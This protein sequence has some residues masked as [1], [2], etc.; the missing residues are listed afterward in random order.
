MHIKV[1]I[2]AFNEPYILK[3]LESLAL[4]SLPKSSTIEIIIAINQTQESSDEIKS[5]N[6]NT[7]KICNNFKIIDIKIDTQLFILEKQ[8]VGL[9]RKM[10]MDFAFKK[11]EFENEIKN[12]IIV[13]L[14]ADCE[15]EKNYFLAIEN[16]FIKYP[17]TPATSIFYEHK[18]TDN[19]YIIDYELHL[20]YLVDAL[21]WTGHPYAFQTVGSSMAVRAECYKKQGGMNSKLAGEDFYFLQKMMDLGNFTD[22]LDT[23]VF[24]SSRVSDRV[25][26][27]T[28][29]AMADIKN[30]EKWKSYH[31]NSYIDIK[32]F[33]TQTDNI[34]IQKFKIESTSEPMKSYLENIDFEN[35][36]KEIIQNTSNYLAFKKRFFQWFNGFMVMK[37]LNFAREN[38]Y[39]IQI[40]DKAILPFLQKIYP[41]NNFSNKTEMLIF[42]RTFDRN[43]GQYVSL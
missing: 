20:R 40:I 27:G 8:S 23:T 24:P 38:F 43:R 3:T 41:N 32:D 37:Y 30:T 13:N 26:F 29:R 35:K 17:K 10:G 2:P 21:R 31:F 1:I 5:Q 33:I 9:A 11:L 7:Y 36:I 42:L 25:P 39:E 16:H 19:Q 34:Y 15:V 22:I 28:G 12:G 6:K 4:C 18:L 14:D